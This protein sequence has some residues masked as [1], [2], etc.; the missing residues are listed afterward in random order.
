MEEDQELV[1]EIVL[2]QRADDLAGADQPD[3]PAGLKL[4]CPD[5]ARNVTRYE[6]GVIVAKSRVKVFRHKSIGQLIPA[7][8]PPSTRIV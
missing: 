7:V 3:I 8:T 4:Q 6:S 5:E 2:K 1:D